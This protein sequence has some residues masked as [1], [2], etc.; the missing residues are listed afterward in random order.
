MTRTGLCLFTPRHAQLPAPAPSLVEAVSGMVMESPSP[1][2]LEP[3]NALMVRLVQ[4]GAAVPLN[5]LSSPVLGGSVPGYGGEQPD[6]VCS[7]AVFS[8]IYTLRG[9]RNW[10][11]APTTSGSGRVSQLSANAWQFLHDS[12]P[13]T[14]AEL[15]HLLGREVTEAA[16]LRA[17]GEL[18]AILRVVPVPQADGAPAIWELTTARFMK[19]IKAGA[20]AG[21]PTAL[22]A[23]VSL[24]LGSAIVAETEEI[25]IFLSPLTARSRVRDVVHGLT[26]ASQLETVVLEGKTLLHIAGDLPDFAEVAEAGAEAEGAAEGAEGAPKKRRS[27]IKTLGDA[28][29]PKEERERRPFKR[30]AEGDGA[31]GSRP[32]SPKPSGEGASAREKK[33]FGKKAFASRVGA[34]GAGRGAEG[35]PGGRTFAGKPR[36]FGDKARTFGDKPRT[37]GDKARTFGDKPRSAGKPEYNKPWAEKA[38]GGEGASERP[39]RPYERKEGGARPAFGAKPAYG[40]KP[41]FGGKP[42][43]GGKPG[44]GGKPSFGPRTPS[45]GSFGARPASGKPSF[46]SKPAFGKKPGFGGKPGFGSRPE[47]TAGPRSEG[48]SNHTNPQFKRFDAPRFPK[49]TGAAPGE[50]RPVDK[51]GNYY[52]GSDSR[53]RPSAEPAARGGKPDFG[54][55]PKFGAKPAFGAK[56]K[57]GGKPGFGAKAGFEGRPKAGFEGRPKAEGGARPFTRKPGGGFAGKAGY[58]ADFKPRKSDTGGKSKPRTRTTT[59]SGQP[60]RKEGAGESGE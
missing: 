32:F 45:T 12:G 59:S 11:Q 31:A 41:A 6:F 33:A 30:P 60:R 58:K 50:N 9:D 3:A 21:Q 4:E 44:F 26:A 25:E 5:L 14:A 49:R 35:R 19:Q 20:N 48:E 27:A 53:P 57:F 7:A 43:Y 13:L 1:A 40:S 42:A 36:A 34:G 37:F 55:K 17:L 39:S 23:L 18:W 47:R 2:A 15:I 29:A 52:G 54:G 51:K 28:A 46:G 8:Y 38:G 56:P 24:Y 22:S 10:K 16:V